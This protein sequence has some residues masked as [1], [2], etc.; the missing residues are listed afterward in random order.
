M[1]RLWFKHIKLLIISLILISTTSAV[2]ISYEFLKGILL[3]TALSKNESK[4]M[5]FVG[6]L[7]VISLIKAFTH[8]LYSRNFNVLMVRSLADLRMAIMKSLLKRSHPEFMERKTGEYLS[9][10]TNQIDTIQYSYYR[11][12]F[13]LLQIITETIFA[14]VGLL[15]IEWRLAIVAILLLIPVIFIPLL[16]KGLISR[17]QKKKLEYIDQHIGRFTEW[18]SGIEIINNYGAKRR[19]FNLFSKDTKKVEKYGV[20]LGMVNHLSYSISTFLTQL[21]LI[22][23][24]IVAAAFLLERSFSVG[25]FFAAVSIMEK[26]NT[27]VVHITNY[28]QALMGARVAIKN[29]NDEINFKIRH[30]DSSNSINSVSNISFDNIDYSYKDSPERKVIK[31][32]SWSIGERGAY[33]ISGESGCGKS[34]LMNLLQNYYSVNKGKICINGVKVDNIKNLSETITIM[35]QETTFFEDTL[36]NNLTMYQSIPDSKIIELMNQLG[37]EKYGNTEALNSTV[38]NGGSNFSGGEA[39]RLSFVR[40]LLKD[41]D[42]LILDE[43][44]ANVDPKSIEKIVETIFSLSKRY[45]F[46]ITHQTT[47]KMEENCVEHIHLSI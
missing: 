4:L 22:G 7:I 36:R 25:M 8:Y 18:I 40:C 15:I 20:E 41:S 6:I 30:K 27:Q 10:Y 46:V 23:M 35:R 12:I 19:F 29:V 45:I 28:A 44:L 47:D 13:G 33:L 21:S 39:R 37:L 31:D 1:K 32:F 11:S 3:D 14:I 42:I 43:P 5:I 9:M 17:I 34:T 26:L 38:L 16:M 2:Q 24:I